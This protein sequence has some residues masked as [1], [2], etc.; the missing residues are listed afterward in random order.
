MNTYYMVWYTQNIFFSPSND[1]Q[2]INAVSS[3]SVFQIIII[4]LICS[5]IL[6]LMHIRTTLF[7]FFKCILLL[8]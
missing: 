1:T 6:K 4:V 8:I 3:L 5:K 7:N 2:I